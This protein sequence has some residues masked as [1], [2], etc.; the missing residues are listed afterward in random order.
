MMCNN[1]VGE[2]NRLQE[3]MPVLMEQ[4]VQPA[5]L[6]HSFRTPVLGVT[7][8]DS[9]WL[10][11]LELPGVDKDDIQLNISERG[12]EVKVEK[13]LEKEEKSEDAYSKYSRYAGF[14]RCFP[15]PEG[16][17]SDKVDA[18]YKNG[19]LEINIPKPVKPEAK[20]IRI[21]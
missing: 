21:K 10:A 17:D 9:S 14:Y 1:I 19:V 11:K 18:E 12:V 8:N 3:L 5:P 16:V 7:E 15:L 13:Q 6:E 20:K 4:L 2:F